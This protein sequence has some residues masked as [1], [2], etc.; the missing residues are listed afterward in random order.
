ML[1][2]HAFIHDDK[3]KWKKIRKLLNKLYVFL[4]LCRIKRSLYTD[5]CNAIFLTISSVRY[6]NQFISTS[7]TLINR[8]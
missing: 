2:A 1:T 8:V 4:Y 6:S 7:F 3:K 5:S